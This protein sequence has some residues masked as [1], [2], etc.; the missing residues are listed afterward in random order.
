MIPVLVVNL[1]R[2]TARRS[3]ITA[4][5][6]ALGI[7][8]RFFDAVDGRSLS[9]DELERLAPQSALLLDRK[10]TPGEI[11]AGASHIAAI[12]QLVDENHDFA[13]VM[14][15][16]A[17]PF[18]DAPL[19]LDPEALNSL[20]QFDVL[21]L[22]S[23]PARWKRPSWQIAQL[24]GHGIYAMARAGFGCQ[25]QVYSRAGLLKMASQLSVVRSS[26]DFM[27]Y[28]DCHIQGLRILEVRPGVIEHDQLD[29]HPELQAALSDVGLRPA[30]DRRT[31]AFSERLRRRRLRY[32][33]KLMAA[34]SFIRAWGIGGLFR[35]LWWW[36][37]GSYFR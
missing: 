16:D 36:P 22:V 14:D 19:F 4:R 28:H 25:G 29:R 5:L 33:R 20:P 8:H 7:K 37:P 10:L 17:V 18:T 27:F 32:R 23:D 11:G 21:R 31:M 35:I 1:K 30:P 24:H 12:R 34:R 13:C 15:D 26:I 9:P 3:A 6:D 2:S